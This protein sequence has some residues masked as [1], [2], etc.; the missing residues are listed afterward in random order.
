MER[1][2]L[3]ALIQERGHRMTPIRSSMVTLFSKNHAP[4]SAEDILKRL[5]DTHK[6]T[7]YRELAFFEEEGLI[8]KID[9]GDGIRRYELAELE[10]H[11][12]LICVSCKKVTDVHLEGDLES[13]ERNISRR[14]GFKILNHALEFFGLCPS[15]K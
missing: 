7:V 5:P 13:Q 12:H 6:T 4:L 15:C 11:H 8:Q 2:K 10:H 1:K 3:I 14:T 9:F